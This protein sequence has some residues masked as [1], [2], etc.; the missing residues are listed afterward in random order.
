MNTPNTRP[1]YL[2]KLANRYGVDL[3]DVEKLAASLGPKEDLDAL[4]LYV[5]FYSTFHT[6]ATSN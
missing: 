5:E 3:A 1:E 2:Q 6:P 4:P